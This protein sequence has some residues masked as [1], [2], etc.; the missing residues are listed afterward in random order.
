MRMIEAQ[1]EPEPEPKDDRSFEEIMPEAEPKDDRSFEEI[2][3]ELNYKQ[4]DSYQ[5]LTDTKAVSANSWMDIYRH[6]SDEIEKKYGEDSPEHELLMQ[7][8]NTRYDIQNE[9]Q[10]E[11]QSQQNQQSNDQSNDFNM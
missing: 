7:D 6:M 5:D 9:L 11:R 4:L 8:Y 1:Q 3:A 10:K 2:M